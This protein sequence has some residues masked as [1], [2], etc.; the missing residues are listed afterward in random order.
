MSQ[1]EP[2]YDQ[3]IA[4]QRANS[5]SAATAQAAA[6]VQQDQ[7]QEILQNPEFLDKLGDPNVD[8]SDVHDWVT[9]EYGPA[10]SKALIKGN[11]DADYPRRQELLNP[12]AVDRAIAERTP[13]R[14]LR[15]HPKLNALAQGITG[16]A[17]YPDPTD[18]PDYRAPITPAKKR[19]LRDAYDI[20]T[21]L[22]SLSAEGKGTD[23]VGTA[24]T[25]NRTVGRRED[26]SK[27][28][29]ERVAG[30]FN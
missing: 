5:A 1:Q 17:E 16:T 27:S 22:Q 6:R 20:R 25:E 14:C 15:Q 26:S 19:V 23:V 13:G 18:N 29:R 11:M 10:F 9:D 7:L 2:S 30:V 3:R 21:L 4:D 24:T 8:E 12:N 28:Y